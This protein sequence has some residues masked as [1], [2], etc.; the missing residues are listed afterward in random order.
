MIA[1]LADDGFNLENG[2]VGYIFGFCDCGVLHL[3][4]RALVGAISP[5]AVGHV[6]GCSADPER[7]TSG[8]DPG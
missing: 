2:D 7:K 6:G 5:S 1:L 8:R 3:F 4:G